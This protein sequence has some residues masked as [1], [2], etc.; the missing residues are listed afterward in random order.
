MPEGELSYV[1][2]VTG[3]AK[4]KRVGAKRLHGQVSQTNGH[5]SRSE[6]AYVEG[7]Y[8]PSCAYPGCPN[9]AFHLGPYNSSP[10]TRFSEASALLVVIILQEL[11][12]RKSA[13]VTSLYYRSCWRLVT[14][15]DYSP[16]PALALLHYIDRI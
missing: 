16:L 13:I 5:T 10:F 6:L 7:G 1:D 9:S 15:V 12:G 3:S 11:A 8:V 4:G 2:V 14:I